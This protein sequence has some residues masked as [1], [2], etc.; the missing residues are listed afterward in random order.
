MAARGASGAPDGTGLAWLSLLKK[1]ALLPSS[2]WLERADLSIHAGEGAP[3]ARGVYIGEGLSLSH[4]RELYR[5]P[6]C[7]RTWIPVWRLRDSILK[8]CAAS[9]VVLVELNSALVFLL[10]DGGWAADSWVRQET[11]LN[12]EFYQRRTRGI[13]RGWGQKVRRQGFQYRL[14]R[15]KDDLI[16]FYQQHYTP[17]L[18]RRHGPGASIRRLPELRAAVRSGFLLQVWRG[19]EWV[20]GLVASR[21]GSRLRLLASGAI[22]S[23]LVRQG[24]L[25][26]AYYFVFR[27]AREA[28]VETIDFCG[29]RPHLLDGVFQHKSLW[30]AQPRHDPWHHT[31]IV[32]YLSRERTLP[33]TVTQQL[34]REGGRY[35]TIQERLSEGPR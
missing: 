4:F 33:E 11:D 16:K 31:E 30:A 22:S 15:D 28:G 32:F 34:V 14:S 5:S 19:E 24:A 18:L 35:V 20:S 25:A 3:A 9:D 1:L 6:S 29:S 8:A 23:L 12:G 10:P 13:E 21:E 26:A 17:H 7:G 27:W 2:L